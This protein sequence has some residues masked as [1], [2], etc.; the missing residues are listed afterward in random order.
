MPK[1]VTRSMHAYLDYPV[2]LLLL[3]APFVLKLG[4][5][6]LMA[7]WLSVVVG[8]A[9][10]LLTLLTDHKLGVLKI[11]PYKVHLAVDFAVGVLFVIAP[12]VLGFNGLDFMYYA[13]LGA[14]VLLVV[15]SHKAEP[16]L[17]Q[18]A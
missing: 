9:A 18:T 11:I 14:T 1:F 2:A 10:F 17:L 5:S 15:G 7:M 12:F 16:D 13:I 4:N 6:N 8:A 3:M